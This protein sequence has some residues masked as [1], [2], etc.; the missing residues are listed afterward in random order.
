[1]QPK[2]T[3]TRGVPLWNFFKQKFEIVKKTFNKSLR[4]TNKL[5][6]N[7]KKILILEREFQSNWILN[8]KKLFYFQVFY[9]SPKFLLKVFAKKKSLFEHTSYEQKFSVCTF[10]STNQVL[11]KTSTKQ[12]QK[13][14]NSFSIFLFYM[15][16][17]LSKTSLNF[18]QLLLVENVQTSMFFLH[19]FKTP[20]SISQIVSTQKKSINKYFSNTIIYLPSRGIV[21]S[22]NE[23][24]L[25]N[26]LQLF[27][28]GKTK[29]DKNFKLKFLPTNLPQKLKSESFFLLSLKKKSYKVGI[30]TLNFSSYFFFFH[31]HP[32]T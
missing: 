30:N 21:K 4:S 24:S 23:A 8:K 28:G 19:F 14:N 25:Y 15:I 9:F 1:M 29:S 13:K 12:L 2:Q 22:I 31:L 3:D 6:N 10:F 17:F 11:N 18:K 26:Q 7:K 20:T 16:V 5:L 32:S 27:N